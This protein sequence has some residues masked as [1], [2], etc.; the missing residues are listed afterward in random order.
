M[1]KKQGIHFYINIRNFADIVEKEE[2]DTGNV[3]HSIHALDAFFSSVEAYGKN[4]YP[5]T[6]IIEKITGSRLHMYVDNSNVDDAFSATSN[7]SKYAVA[8]SRYMMD[9]VSK[10]KTLSYFEIQIGAS[11]G[12]F[13]E[14]VFRDNSIE[15]LTTIGYVAN[16]AAKLQN[17]SEP[18]H[19]LISQSIYDDIV[20]TKK[21]LFIPKHF[22]EIKKY[23]QSVCYDAEV[24]SICDSMDYTEDFNSFLTIANKINL[25][26]MNFRS[27]DK[28]LSYQNLSKTECKKIYGIPL[29]ADIRG[30]TSQFDENDLNLE[31]M[32]NKTQ[33]V[34]QSMYDA[35]N[36]CK[37]VHVQ[38]QGDREMALFHNYST[39]T[40]EE[41]AVQ[42]GLRIIDVVKPF[43]V[44]VGVGEA[45]G[46]LFAAKIGARGEKDNILIGRTVLDADDCED[47][48]AKENQLVITEA[49][50]AELAK[51]NKT[52]AEQFSYMGNHMYF[53]KKSYQE[54]LFYQ[55]QKCLNSNN[56]NQTYNGAWKYN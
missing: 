39:Y 47:K 23:D 34:L 35:V 15:E 20:S 29:F 13:Y 1:R 2:N 25:Q 9:N 42:A 21:S 31:E 51:K 27:A 6:V 3:V 48:Y 17:L 18:D 28:R 14:F 45:I 16:Y 10:Y 49:V 8:L 5:D 12:H 33:N 19:I 43:H 11:Y 4:H 54:Y 44:S 53:T 40:C 38:F 50:Y 7:I 32:T 26:D 46:K 36:Y 41:D 56:K 52:L 22:E 37:G 24:R 55:E 30:F